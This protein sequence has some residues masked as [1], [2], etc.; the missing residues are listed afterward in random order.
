MLDSI[1]YTL[2]FTYFLFVGFAVYASF[3]QAWDKLKIGIKVLYAPVLIVFGLADVVFNFTIGS[4]MFLERAKTL[5]FS[6]R[7]NAHLNDPNWRGQLAGAF[8][9]PLNALY[10]N[11]IHPVL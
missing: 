6:Q 1:L 5:T 7:L 9:V 3:I 4:A 2:G 11:H 8:S 10:P